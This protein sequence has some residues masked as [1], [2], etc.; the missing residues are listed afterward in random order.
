MCALTNG[1]DDG[2]SA[3]VPLGRI[4]GVEV[5]GP[6]QLGAVGEVEERVTHDGVDGE[7]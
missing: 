7:E 2:G 1:A 3:V 6:F 5:A 4:L